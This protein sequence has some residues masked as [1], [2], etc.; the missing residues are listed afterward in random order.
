MRNKKL[1]A[2]ALLLLT[3]LIWGMAFVAQR[4][5]MDAVSPF[6]FNGTR[7]LIGGLVLLPC[8]RFLDKGKSAKWPIL[9]GVLCGIV[10]FL[11]STLQQHGIVTSS[12]GKAGFITALYIIMVPVFGIFVKRHIPWAVWAGVLL[13]ICG[14]YLLCGGNG[15]SIEAGDIYLLLGSVSFALH[16]LIIDYFAPKVDCVRMSCIQFFVAG[17]L[18]TIAMFVFETPRLGDIVSAGVPILYAGVL[19]C[20]VAYTLQTVAQ[21]DTDPA[22][23]ALICSLESVFALIGGVLIMGEKFTSRE[24]WGCLIIFVAILLAQLPILQDRKVE[25]K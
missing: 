18:S 22:S 6:T 19:S 10:L 8:I 20:G 1:R 4:K 9:A 11:G 7:S 16:I 5:G 2:N 24:L 12:A 15:F 17:I 21:K 25:K 13:S 3:A 23:A 14:M